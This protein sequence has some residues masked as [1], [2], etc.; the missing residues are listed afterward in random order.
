MRAEGNRG[1]PAGSIVKLRVAF[2]EVPRAGSVLQL[3]TGRRYWVF[4]Q[5]GKT[6]HC[7]VMAPGDPVPEI[8]IG[9]VS[10]R[11]AGRVRKVQDTGRKPLA[12][13][14]AEACAASNR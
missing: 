12:Q 7:R 14:I 2:G 3:P 11:W 6:L 9:V 4:F 8:A 13:L 10:W 1:K 5:S